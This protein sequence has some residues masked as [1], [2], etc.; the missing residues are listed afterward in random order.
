MQDGIHWVSVGSCT[1]GDN[2]VARLIASMERN[3]RGEWCL[4]VWSRW[5]TTA[6]TTTWCDCGLE[7][8]TRIE[9]TSVCACVYS[10]RVHMPQCTLTR[11]SEHAIRVPSH[12]AARLPT[13]ACVRHVAIRPTPPPDAFAL[14]DTLS[15]G[16]VRRNMPLLNRRPA[17]TT[18][19]A[20]C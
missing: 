14:P 9:M 13:I 11:L 4:G 15:I 5:S 2:Q 12:A 6:W 1:S 7:W 20:L 10:H 19:C 3:P 17:I 16:C 8:K 18:P